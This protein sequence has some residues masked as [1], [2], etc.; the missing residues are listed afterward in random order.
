MKDYQITINGRE[1]LAHLKQDDL[2]AITARFIDM[3]NRDFIAWKRA[4][5]ARWDKANADTWLNIMKIEGKDRQTRMRELYQH[6]A[7]EE[8]EAL[9]SYRFILPAEFFY[10]IAYKLLVKS[11]VW[12][13]RKPFR[14]WR[15]IKRVIH[16]DEIISLITFIGKEIL[17]G[18]VKTPDAPEVP[19]PGK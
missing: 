1:Y 17:P 13:F 19:T 6:K 8:A 3:A 7:E 10:R 5:N 18:A 16:H 2:E 15:Q 14:S 11:G 9:K 12:P 4:F